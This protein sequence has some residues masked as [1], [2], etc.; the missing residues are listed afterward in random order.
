MPKEP[1]T[2]PKAYE[3]QEFLHSRD[4]RALRILA[5]YHE[6]M[7]RLAHY[8]VT[9]TVVFMGSARLHSAE[10]AAAAVA[11]AKR[12]DGDPAAAE[13]GRAHV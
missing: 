8:N 13:I 10:D 5:E 11:A 9:D 6:P 4:G 7:S 3:N 2:Y 12:G 1:T